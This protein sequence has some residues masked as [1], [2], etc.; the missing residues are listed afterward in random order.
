[1]QMYNFSW[2]H[3]GVFGVITLHHSTRCFYW[4]RFV[5][6]YVVV[7]AKPFILG[8]RIVNNYLEIGGPASCLCCRVWPLQV[9]R[10]FF[11]CFLDWN[12]TALEF[13]EELFMLWQV[14]IIKIYCLTSDLIIEN[15]ATHFFQLHIFLIFKSPLNKVR[16]FRH[17]G[18]LCLLDPF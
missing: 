10:L 17:E 3:L 2:A 9:L 11:L 4:R 18:I 12:E 6:K 15:I 8:E 1:M 7:H 13:C 16:F 5:S 14:H